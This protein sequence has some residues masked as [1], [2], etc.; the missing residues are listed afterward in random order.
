MEGFVFSYPRRAS[1]YIMHIAFT[2]VL[3]TK[4]PCQS[5]LYRVLWLSFGYRPL[6]F[7]NI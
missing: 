1:S 3:F 4:I 2:I 6:Y 7:A 5:D